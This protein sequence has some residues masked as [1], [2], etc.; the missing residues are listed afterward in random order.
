M[1]SKKSTCLS[2]AEFERIRGDLRDFYPTLHILTQQNG[3]T[4]VFGCFPVLDSEGKLLDNYRVSIFL[5]AS[6]P[7]SLPIVYEVGGRIPKIADRHI[8]DDGSACVFYPDDRWRCFPIGAPFIDYLNGPLRNYFLSQT[9]YERNGEWP[10][11]EW[12]H[13]DIG[14]IEYYQQLIEAQ[15]IGTVIKF[16]F[17]LADKK[18]RKQ[19]DCPC[20]SEKTIK[21]CC[22]LKI[23][24]LRKKID[25]FTAIRALDNLYTAQMYRRY[26][27]LIKTRHRAALGVG[28]RRQRAC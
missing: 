17:V 12:S 25:S 10:F 21:N 9:Y 4:E 1:H 26:V 7:A 15:D 18:I 6:Y 28:N 19:H 3:T 13:G 22:L 24:D 5:P 8:F 14:V 27:H 20:G 11:G 2:E 23:R 16:L